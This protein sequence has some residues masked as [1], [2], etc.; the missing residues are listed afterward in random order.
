MAMPPPHVA[1]VQFNPPLS[2]ERKTLC[3]R[4]F[5]GTLAKVLVLYP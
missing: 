1:K 2:P 4:T 3:E 5:M